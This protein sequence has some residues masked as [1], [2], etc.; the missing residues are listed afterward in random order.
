MQYI[1]DTTV[2][3]GHVEIDNLPFPDLTRIKVLLFPEADIKNMMFMKAC[4]L[5][6]NIKGNISD[7]IDAER[8]ER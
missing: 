7:D 6:K 4:E 5:T 3:K 1:I 8:G 2:T